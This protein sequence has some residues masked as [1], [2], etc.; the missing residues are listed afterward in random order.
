MLLNIL[1]IILLNR[2]CQRRRQVCLS[3]CFKFGHACKDLHRQQKHQQ[4]NQ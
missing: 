3:V 2:V 4:K 1:V